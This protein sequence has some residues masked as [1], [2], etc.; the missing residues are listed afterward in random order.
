MYPIPPAKLWP[1][2]VNG[3]QG[4]EGIGTCQVTHAGTSRFDK[5]IIQEGL[6]PPRKQ[7]WSSWILKQ[8]WTLGHIMAAVSSVKLIKTMI[9]R[10]RYF[11]FAGLGDDIQ[12]INLQFEDIKNS[13]FFPDVCVWLNLKRWSPKSTMQ[14]SLLSFWVFWSIPGMA[15]SVFVKNRPGDLTRSPPAPHAMTSA[16]LLL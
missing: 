8:R 7:T 15:T 2:P 9:R 11:S 10:V 5:K 13:T 14:S 1:T 16:M 4:W 6:K 3:T 12:E